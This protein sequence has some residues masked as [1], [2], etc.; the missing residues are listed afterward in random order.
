MAVAAAALAA[1]TTSPDTTRTG[2]ASPGGPEDPDR[3]LRQAVAADEVRLSAAYA[4]VTGLPAAL[5]TRVAQ[6]GQRHAVYAAAVLPGGAS[7]S[8]PTL[9]G[10]SSGATVTGT[11]SA[12]ATPRPADQTVD[13]AVTLARLR[14]LETQAAAERAVQS[15]TATDPELAR[16]IVLAG[17]GAISAAQVLASLRVVR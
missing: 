6:L 14:A 1:C 8:S 16:T 3:A 12:P 13:A 17:T 10:S 2:P 5:A 9:S 11:P 15:V 4:A 7:P